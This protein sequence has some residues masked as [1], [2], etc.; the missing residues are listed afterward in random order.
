MS[1]LEGV[2]HDVTRRVQWTG[3]PVGGAEYF[4]RSGV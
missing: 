4:R 1:I 3:G 2:R